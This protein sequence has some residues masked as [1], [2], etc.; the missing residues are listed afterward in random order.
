[1]RARLDCPLS[2]NS[3]HECRRI[4]A[5]N[6]TLGAERHGQVCRCYRIATAGMIFFKNVQKYPVIG[7][8]GS[9]LKARKERSPEVD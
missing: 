9:P 3:G 7:A 6:L 8:N 2:A 5:P 1:M 4:K